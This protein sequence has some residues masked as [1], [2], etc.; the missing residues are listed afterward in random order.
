MSNVIIPTVGRKVWFWPQ[1]CT[2]EKRNAEGV[3]KPFA[4]S[5]LGGVTAARQPMDATV[6]YVWHDRMVNLLVLDHYGNAFPV[7]SATLVQD[8]D[9]PPTGA[10]CEWMPFQKGQAAKADAPAAPVANISS[11]HRFQLEQQLVIGA[12]GTLANAPHAAADIARGIKNFLDTLHPISADRLLALPVVDQSAPKAR[13][14]DQNIEAEIQAKGADVAPRITPAD[15][16][17]NIS[18]V[19][20]FTG[21][22]GVI[23]ES[24][25]DF[26]ARNVR[27]ELKLLTFCVMVLRNGHTVTGE[28]YCAD[29]AKFNA[30]T[31]RIEARKVAKEKIWSLMIYEQRSKLTQNT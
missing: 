5:D 16:E 15:V 30:E 28:S 25:F 11:D 12:A 6:V 8:G 18:S 26:D 21:A 23:G 4:P 17:A 27:P 7:T 10:Y 2:F 29:P 13:T 31:G 14:T 24:G 9:E 19:H 1:D 3:L 22:D 20:F